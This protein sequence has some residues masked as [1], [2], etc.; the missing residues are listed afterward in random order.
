MIDEWLINVHRA[1]FPPRCVLCDAKGDGGHDICTGCLNDLPTLGPACRR[2][3]L[4]LPDAPANT[5]CGTCLNSS[6]AFD[7]TLALYQYAPPVDYMIQQL[8]FAGRLY[9]APVLG[10][11]L[12]R[13]IASHISPA[14][15]MPV[16]LH[17]SRLRERGFNQAMELARP[18]A[19]RLR[20]PIHARICRRTRATTAQS[21][22][23]RQG[24]RSNVRN[25]FTVRGPLPA[26]HIAIVDD[27][28]TTGST[29]N[30]LA[31]LLKQ[32][33]AREV[34]VIVAARAI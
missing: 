10:A 22:M 20:I 5:L 16:P 30:E 19:H 17:R 3:G 28:M 21:G 33:G 26:S 15:L 32:N 11:L 8:K 14:C 2:C 1:L 23:P 18:I 13:H 24:R 27:V 29:V 12:A 4:P 34:S 25:A 7:R 31:R 9:F 6:P